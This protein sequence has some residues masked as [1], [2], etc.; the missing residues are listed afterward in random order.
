[1]DVMHT[2]RL[3]TARCDLGAAAD[4]FT[5]FGRFVVLDA[6]VAYLCEILRT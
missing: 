5:T 6:A 1:M 2:L 4:C 3:S